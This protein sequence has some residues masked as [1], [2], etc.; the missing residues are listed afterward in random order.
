MLKD[1]QRI[2]NS[3]GG[4]WKDEPA[5][6]ARKSH[7]WKPGMSITLRRHSVLAHN[8]V[9]INVLAQRSSSKDLKSL[10]KYKSSYRP[11]ADV[12][13]SYDKLPYSSKFTAKK[14]TD[15]SYLHKSD[16]RYVN[17]VGKGGFGR[18]WKV[19]HRGSLRVFALK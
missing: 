7:F 8:G 14:D 6:P 5:T 19:E 3:F 17:M 16:Y 18:V 2:R 10:Q 15:M 4:R 1:S 11:E 9:N 12:R 13:R